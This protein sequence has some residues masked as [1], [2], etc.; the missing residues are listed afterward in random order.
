MCQPAAVRCKSRTLSASAC[1][2]PQWNERLCAST[3]S[4]SSG[5]AISS[6]NVPPGVR[7]SYCN[8]IGGIPGSLTKWTTTRSNQLS[9]TP[10]TRR[11]SS[12]KRRS[13][14]SPPG[15]REPRRSIVASSHFIE[16]VR[17]YSSRQRSSVTSSTCGPS[18]HNVAA[19]LSVGMAST[20]VMSWL[21]S[22]RAQRRKSATEWLRESGRGNQSCGMGGW[23]SQPCNHAADVVVQAVPG[24]DNVE[25]YAACSGGSGNEV[26]AQ[27]TA[28]DGRLRKRVL[29]LEY[30]AKA[31]RSARLVLVFTPQLLAR[32][33]VPRDGL[34]HTC[35]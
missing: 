14:A 12:S 15:L 7:I 2:A 5:H 1:W 10:S 17:R 19:L 30:Q 11:G 3:P 27:M 33:F 20:V 24:S 28:R 6:R 21:G 29:T 31:C 25:P 23:S 16:L 4:I 13:A 26:N 9:V 34:R 18:E 35:D 22:I 8:S 32:R